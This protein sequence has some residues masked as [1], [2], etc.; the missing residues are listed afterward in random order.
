M[1]ARAEKPGAVL[2]D[3][4]GRHHRHTAITCIVGP[5]IGTGPLRSREGY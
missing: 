3:G 5:G 4:R 2:N 1:V